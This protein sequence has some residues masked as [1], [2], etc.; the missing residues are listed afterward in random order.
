M[1]TR[2]I[3]RKQNKRK[4]EQ[5]MTGNDIREYFETHNCYEYFS[6]QENEE[7]GEIYQEFISG[8]GGRQAKVRWRNRA[9][10]YNDTVGGLADE[11]IMFA[12]TMEDILFANLDKIADWLTNSEEHVLTLSEHMP[13]WSVGVYY[14]PDGAEHDVH[15]YHLRIKRVP[16]AP[17]GF[18]YEYFTCT[19]PSW[20]E[21]KD[22]YQPPK[23]VPE[24]P[25]INGCKKYKFGTTF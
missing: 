2:S 25:Y 4:G 6:L 22:E 17:L 9:M 10:Q 19:Y 24:E 23:E 8:R 11:G 20:D 5:E 7:N 18:L 1:A 14:T 15:D 21:I 12:F 3:G 16:K 13:R